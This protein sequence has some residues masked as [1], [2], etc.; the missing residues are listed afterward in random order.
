ME[1]EYSTPV[2]NL[3]IKQREV[4]KP[5][6]GHSDPVQK[7]TPKADTPKADTQRYNEKHYREL[8]R[9]E[10]TSFIDKLK[11]LSN[12]NSLQEILIIG[13][14]YIILT[15]ESYSSL[16]TKYLPA[17]ILTDSKFNTLGLLITAILFGV[18][19]VIT[20]TFC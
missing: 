1:S 8:L 11:T 15:S 2:A 12:K 7:N 16:L 10:N 14:L 13:I 4:E 20:K 19:F 18:L 17:V 5:Q 6:S 3:P 9:K